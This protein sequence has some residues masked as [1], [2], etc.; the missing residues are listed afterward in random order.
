LPLYGARHTFKGFIDDLRGLSE[1]SPKIVMGDASAT[2]TS[3]G[4]GPKSITEE[5]AEVILGLSN[6]MID[7]MATL[8]LGAKERADRGKL[9]II[10]AWRN[11]ERSSTRNCKSCSQNARNSIVET[12]SFL[13]EVGRPLKWCQLC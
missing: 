12:S 13:T 6:S 9:K 11:D 7:R 5:Q 8:L 3:G 4:Y 2:D 10:D 1:R